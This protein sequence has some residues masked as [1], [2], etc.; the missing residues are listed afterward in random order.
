MNKIL[1][2]GALIFSGSAFAQSIGPAGCGLGHMMMG[3]KDSQVL[4]ATLNATGTQSF[5]ITSGTSNCVDSAGTAKLESFI[6][7]NR[8]ALE[9][10]AA[11]GQGETVESLAQILRCPS[12][13]KV[14]AVLKASH[15]EVFSGSN[16]EVT[17]KVRAA[18]KSNEVLCVSQG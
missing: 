7:G 6:E 16:N 11:R 10:E 2:L 12:S 9:T 8:V 3:G 14:G 15:S 5:G 18:L 17:A 1:L 13:E 4:V